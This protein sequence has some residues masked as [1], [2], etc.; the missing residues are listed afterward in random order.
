MSESTKATKLTEFVNCDEQAEEDREPV[1]G[2]NDDINEMVEQCEE[3]AVERFDDESIEDG[4]WFTSLSKWQDGDF[5]VEVKHGL[6]YD[7][8]PYSQVVEMVVYDHFQERMAYVKR[9]RF[10][11]MTR[12][13][14]N[15]EHEVIMG[16]KDA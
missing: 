8:N 12:Q 9:R 1:V 4:D 5:R 11:C 2:L 14:E 13:D 7:E 16:D 6:G 3:A 15:I 10:P